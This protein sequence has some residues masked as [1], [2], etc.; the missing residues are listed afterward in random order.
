MCVA[1]DKS[2]L[3]IIGTKEL[4]RSRL[5]DQPY[6]I[7]VDGQV[8][9]ESKSEKLLGVVMNNTMTWHE[10][11]HGEDWRNEGNTPG[12]IPQ[13]S[14]RLGILKKL[15]KFSSRKKLEMLAAGLFYSKLSYCLP[16]FTTTWGLDIYREENTRF[17]SY[18][19]E[20]NRKLQVLQNQVCRLL[21][22]EAEQ[23]GSRYI[24]QNLTTMDLMSKTSQL[25]VH[26][27]GALSTL[28][29]IK[30]ILLSGKPQYISELVQEHPLSPKEHLL[31]SAGRASHTEEP[32]CPTSCQKIS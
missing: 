6:S 18:T 5:G 32:N 11:L 28:I 29:M 23:D 1:G 13:L 12:L 7:L 22:T 8:V 21:L 9:T 16:L 3:L 2:K 31:L 17:T 14:Q 15:S 20:D 25:S 26:Q 27:L 30:K 4:R 19:K 10:H 24:R